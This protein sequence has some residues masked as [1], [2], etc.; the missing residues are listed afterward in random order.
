MRAAVRRAD[1]VAVL[2]AHSPFRKLP[3]EELMRRI[4]IDAA[5]LTE[6]WGTLIDVAAEAV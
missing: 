3:R 2:V 6:R 1:I 4:V 5:G